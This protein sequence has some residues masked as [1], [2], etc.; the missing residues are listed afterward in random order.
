LK[1]DLGE[2]THNTE[3]IEWIIVTPRFSKGNKNSRKLFI[4]LKT[5]ENYNMETKTKTLE[6]KDHSNT[7]IIVTP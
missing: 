2:H 3:L 4:F 5:V 6:N 7:L 1:I